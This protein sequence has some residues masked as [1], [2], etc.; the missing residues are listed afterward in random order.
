MLKCG[1]LIQDLVNKKYWM[2]L[3]GRRK[4]TTESNL[5]VQKGKGK[6]EEC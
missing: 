3:L 4:M 1:N 6:Q 5:D 2:K